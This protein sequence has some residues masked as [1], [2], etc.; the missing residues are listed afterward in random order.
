MSQVS[1]LRHRTRIIATIGPAS[2]SA[3]TIE[4]LIRAG[5]NVS[6]HNLSHGTP[7]EHTRHIQTVRRLA[8]RLNITVAVLI[9][10]PG[11]KYRTLD[12]SEGAV[13]LK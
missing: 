5:M 12:L 1:Y 6:R 7:D 3:G 2:S 11:P 9:D 13:T 10:L 4:R 8:R